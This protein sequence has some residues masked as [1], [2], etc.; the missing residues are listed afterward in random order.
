MKKTYTRKQIQE[1]ISYWE[2]QLAEGNYRKVNEEVGLESGRH[3]ILKIGAIGRWHAFDENGNFIKAAESIE[4]L[5][6]LIGQLH[7]EEGYDTFEFG[8]DIRNSE[9]LN[10]L[11]YHDGTFIRG[12]KNV[13]DYIAHEIAKWVFD[14]CGELPASTL[15]KIKISEYG[16]VWK[17]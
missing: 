17:N 9:R 2:R 7:I 10:S 11:V 15:S 13:F 16:I 1:A 4:T 3:V 8:E 6:A 14:E 5:P 12:R